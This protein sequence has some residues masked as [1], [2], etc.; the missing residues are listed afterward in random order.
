MPGA[1]SMLLADTHP[2]RSKSAPAECRVRHQT[3]AAPTEITSTGH[4]SQ[5]DA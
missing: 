5:P 4:P 1:T 3:W 2:S